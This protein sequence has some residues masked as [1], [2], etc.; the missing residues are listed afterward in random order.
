MIIRLKDA[1]ACA[2]DIPLLPIQF[3]TYIPEGWSTGSSNIP[4]LSEYME[5][6]NRKSGI[7]TSDLQTINHKVSETGAT[8]YVVGSTSLSPFCNIKP[9]DTDIIITGTKTEEDLLL[10]AHH[11]ISH[12]SDTT[13]VNRIFIQCGIVNMEC[14]DSHTI[15]IVLV[16]YPSILDFFSVVDI[17]ATCVA[18]DGEDVLLT[19]G[20]LK[21]IVQR[22]IYVRPTTYS[23]Q[24]S[25]RLHK[26]VHRKTPFAIAFPHMSRSA[27]LENL[28]TL[29]DVSL[30][31]GLRVMFVEVRGLY[32]T[33]SLCKHLVE[34]GESY[35]GIPHK[36]RFHQNIMNVRGL[37]HGKFVLKSEEKNI[38]PSS[39]TLHDL[40]H[41]TVSSLLSIQEMKG[42]CKLLEIS[43]IRRD[44]FHGVK[45]ELST[46]KSVYGLNSVEVAEMVTLLM[47]E[48]KNVQESRDKLTRK[49][50]SV[51]EKVAETKVRFVS[52]IRATGIPVEKLYGTLFRQ[53]V[54]AYKSRQT[55]VM[56][57]QCL[58]E[59][60]RK[61]KKKTDCV[62]CGCIISQEESTV[63]F[64]CAHVC[65]YTSNDK[66]KGIRSHVVD[67]CP[68]CS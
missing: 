1:S 10:V 67:N 9:G 43:T 16:Q 59:D 29:E 53:D 7:S 30:V 20:A 21:E 55:I 57:L 64:E 54:D 15:Q 13:Q 3:M 50:M 41:S 39:I 37:I 11:I 28:G 38:G 26:Y 2:N 61:H 22:C 19:P 65:H 14:E 66:C 47:M 60:M 40:Q 17:E 45:I 48:S 25:E 34:D 58:T 42:V 6:F 63:K 24:T 27:F 12:V 46:M 23:P 35:D 33:G 8:V 52:G 51:Y 4:S 5:T 44:A 36:W 56:S 62:L 68:V 18:N 49:L 31:L 32:I